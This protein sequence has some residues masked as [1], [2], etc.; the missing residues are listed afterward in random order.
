MTQKILEKFNTLPCFSK[1]NLKLSQDNSNYSFD[2]NIQNWLARGIIKQ[3]KNGLY[4]SERYILAEKDITAYSEFI[5]S[6]LVY[7]S[8]LSCEYVLQKYNLLTEAIYTITS[9]T[10]KTTRTIKNFL[11]KF[12]YYNLKKELITGF[13]EFSYKNNKYWQATK[14]KALFDYI[15]LRKNNFFNFSL[16]ELSELRLNTD[17][18]SKNDLRELKKYIQLSND[19][20]M[21]KFFTNFQKLCLSKS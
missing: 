6:K 7:P 20:K 17:E 11:A 8:Y 13:M 18:F 9:V 12:S 1:Q 21:Q 10:S 2:K 5:A 16:A 3:L 4:V 19:V 15:Y 14:A